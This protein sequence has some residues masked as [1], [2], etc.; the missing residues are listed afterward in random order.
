MRAARPGQP[1]QPW[2]NTC[3]C[4][5][6]RPGPAVGLIGQYHDLSTAPH[7]EYLGNDIYGGAVCGDG[8]ALPNLVNCGK[9]F[10]LPPP[11]PLF[12]ENS[13]EKELGRSRG[14]GA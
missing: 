10:T 5:R 9:S 6:R 7:W 13:G 2:G 12:G 1:P 4:R 3:W 11:P 14:P 8:T